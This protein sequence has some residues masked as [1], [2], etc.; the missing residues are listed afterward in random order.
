MTSDNNT[1][2][3]LARSLRIVGYGALAALAIALFVAI[4][5]IL[6]DSALDREATHQAPTDTLELHG[7]TGASPDAAPE[8]PTA[9]A[10]G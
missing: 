5:A 10:P 4:C 3:A 9:R 1:H 2:A 8:A 6:R 7:S